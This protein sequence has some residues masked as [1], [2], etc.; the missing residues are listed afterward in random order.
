MC[1]KM[2]ATV[3]GACT[4]LSVETKTMCFSLS[5]VAC[6]TTEGEIVQ[7]PHPDDD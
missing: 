3:S 6:E 2:I 5:I 4:V 7:T 1:G